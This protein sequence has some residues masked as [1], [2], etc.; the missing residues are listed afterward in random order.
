MNPEI[1]KSVLVV[2]EE[3]PIG[4]IAN[5]AAILGM[6]LGKRMPELVGSDVTDADKQTHLGII[7]IPLPILKA[8]AQ[9]VCELRNQLYSPD[10]ADLTVVDFSDLA[11]SCKEY[12][13]YIQKIGN[14]NADA[15][16]YWG[17]AI[18]GNKKKVNKLTGSLPLLR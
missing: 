13:D 8:S 2:D 4:L 6:T 18:V 10:F 7:E 3:L 5:T 1:E 17:I 12:D 15:L 11:Q 9:K 16:S 14:T